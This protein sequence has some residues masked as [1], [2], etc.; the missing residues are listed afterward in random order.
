MQKRVFAAALALFV[1]A[2]SAS[3]SGPER[4]AAAAAGSH[5]AAQDGDASAGG[6]ARSGPG[7]RSAHT[8]A[9]PASLELRLVDA[10]AD[11]VTSVFVTVEAI[12]ASISGG[13]T[14]LTSERHTVD[15]LTLQG[16]DY[17]S[18]GIASLPPGRVGQL[19]L[20]LAEDGEQH[21]VTSDGVAH[22]LRV[23]S[24]DSSGIKLVGGFE[25]PECA[26]GYVS[27]DFDA[28]RSLAAPKDVGQGA[29][30]ANDE[31]QLS[32]VIRLKAIVTTGSCADDGGAGEASAERGAAPDPCAALTCEESQVC[33]NG[34]CREA[35]TL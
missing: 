1:V 3:E 23:P 20:R 32:P 26:T 22:P 6:A 31:W 9:R 34:T 25:V 18:L 5:A 11:D 27:I 10:P 28:K 14:V 13:W 33:V 2:C 12:E 21:V 7:A 29:K 24:G 4:G 35:A 16:G 19:R 8:T 15:L 17:L 30:P